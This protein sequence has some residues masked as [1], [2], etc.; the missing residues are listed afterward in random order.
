MNLGVIIPPVLA[1]I[2]A[3]LLVGIISRTKAFFAGRVGPPLLQPYYDLRKLL[4]KGAVYS[5]TTTWIFRAG[6]IVSLAALLLATLIVP[7][8]SSGAVLSF[9]GDLILFAYLL[10]LARLFTVLAA[11]GTGV[12]FE[13]MGASR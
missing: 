7:F 13:G 12:S 6:P 5:S 3:P 2:L 9:P 4:G 1:L 8:G 10:G 11:L